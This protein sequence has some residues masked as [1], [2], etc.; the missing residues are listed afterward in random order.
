MTTNGL[1]IGY[2]GSKPP[3]T[4][5]PN[6]NLS[7]DGIKLVGLIGKNGS[8]KSTLLRTLSGL[9]KPLQGEVILN[10]ENIRNIDYN[11]RASLV[12]TVLSDYVIEQNFTVKEV[13]EMGRFS[14]ARW[15]MKLDNENLE[16]VEKNIEF[17]QL[18]SLR[19]QKFHQLSDGQKQKVLIARALAQDTPLVFLD[20]PTTHLD[21]NH[22]M[23]MFLL[24]KKM[25]EQEQKTV[26]LS[27]HEIELALKL[28]DEI[29]LIDEDK[30]HIAK[31]SEIA[32]KDLI[33]KVFHSKNVFFNKEV[34]SFEYKID[35]Q[36][37][38][39]ID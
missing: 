19:D 9:Q 35:K 30:I 23:E 1:D 33:N 16:I 27:T 38:P 2:V 17:V 5:L 37:K 32:N 34:G 3:K 25:V 11:K 8:G 14:Q 24:F 15:D 36:S 10:G 31:P 29:W 26:L 39:K 6:C 21:V 13:V 7:L 22:R 12:A 4:V 28:C 18:E 20:E